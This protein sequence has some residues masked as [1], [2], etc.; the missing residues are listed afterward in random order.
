M[1]KRKHKDKKSYLRK[2]LKRLEERLLDYL[3]ESDESS[4]ERYEDYDRYYYENRREIEQSEEPMSDFDIIPLSDSDD[5]SENPKLK[6]VIAS[7]TGNDKRPPE[8]PSAL[9]PDGGDNTTEAVCNSAP[10]VPTNVP[11]TNPGTSTSNEV[12]PLPDDI[13]EALGNPKGKEEVF[14]PKIPEEIAK[15]WGRVLVDGLTKEQK[16]EIIEK[17]LIPDNFRLVKAPLLNQEIIPV[18][19]EAARNRDKLLEKSQN[20]LG[21]GISGLTNIA[22]DIIEDKTNKIE[23]LKKLSEI[24]QIFLDL[25]Y[26]DT[27]RRRKL[28]TSSLDKKF[29]NMISDVKRDTYLF[30]VNL[31]EK[32][33]ASKS[34]ERSGLQ[35]KR[36]DQIALS[37]RKQHYQQGNWRNPPRAPAQRAH[38]QGGKNRY[39]SQP[40][41]RPPPPPDRPPRAPMKP[42]A[43]T[44]KRQ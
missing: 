10:S 12:T 40:S 30:G 11:S 35:I 4:D 5:G 17:S 37:S 28:I 33:K 29:L 26:E 15:R 6:S 43:S 20:Q 19:S 7:T 14:G 22:S 41:R 34:A 9:N 44:R 24:S 36:T 39:A 3:S 2:K 8:T 16:Q 13:L 18:L 31:S 27:K 32:M 1:G 23:L 21:L 38:R 25:H 42:S